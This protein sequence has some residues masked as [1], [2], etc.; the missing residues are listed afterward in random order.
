MPKIGI[1]IKP[2]LI[3]PNIKDTVAG[4]FNLLLV[5][6]IQIATHCFWRNSIEPKGI[7]LLRLA[8]IVHE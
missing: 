7:L 6:I 4:P 8:P 1:Q 2:I 5:L 3:M